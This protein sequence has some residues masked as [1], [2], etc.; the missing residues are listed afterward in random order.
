[1]APESHHTISKRRLDGGGNRSQSGSQTA[2][3]RGSPLVKGFHIFGHV[4]VW[5]TR[6]ILQT[7]AASQ[8]SAQRG[9]LNVGMRK[10]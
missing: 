3:T 8:N 6:P 1:M 4:I 10:T 2:P 9:R 5:P 7:L